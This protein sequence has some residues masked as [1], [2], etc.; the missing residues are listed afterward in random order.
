M[1]ATHSEGHAPSHPTP[2]VTVQMLQQ[3]YM[4][5]GAVRVLEHEEVVAADWD[6]QQRC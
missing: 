5:S 4:D 2:D 1:L 6:G 3:P